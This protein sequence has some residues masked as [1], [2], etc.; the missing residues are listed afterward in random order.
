MQNKAEEQESEEKLDYILQQY[1]VPYPDQDTVDSVIDSLRQY[2]PSRKRKIIY[3]YESLKRLIKDGTISIN[4][5][6]LSFW[7]ITLFL[8]AA[9]YLVLTALEGDPYKLVFVIAPMPVILGL[10]EVFRGREEG[11]VELEMACKITPQEMIISKILVI[12]CYNV[13]LNMCLTLILYLQNPVIILWKVTLFWLCPMIL[14]GSL[15]LWFCSKIKGNYAILMSLSLWTAASFILVSQERLFVGI[16]ELNP[17]YFILFIC[18][19]AGLFI[20][21]IIKFKGGILYGIDN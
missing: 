5:M 17:W 7:I 20:K 3:H 8:Y 12:C 21:E 18:T 11:V 14:T 2:V 9:G 10:L 19:G 16:I 4:F 13:I 15:S 1:R 6:E